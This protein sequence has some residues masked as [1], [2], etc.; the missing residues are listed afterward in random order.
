MRLEKLFSS[1]G[2][3]GA[4]VFVLSKGTA[5]M[6]A[7]VRGGTVALVSCLPPSHELFERA[8]TLGRVKHVFVLT[9]DQ[10]DH[11]SAWVKRF[12]A[13]L[14]SPCAYTGVDMLL[15]HDTLL[16]FPGKVFL[17]QSTLQVEVCL[18]VSQH[19]LVLCG[20]AVPVSFSD[21]QCERWIRSHCQSSC[22]LARDYELLLTTFRPDSFLSFSSQLPVARREVIRSIVE[23]NNRGLLLPVVPQSVSRLRILWFFLF[24]FNVFVFLV[25]VVSRGS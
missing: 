17:F 21:T 24:L 23:F 2:T 25:Y 20:S 7:V 3:N 10:S 18:F 5:R 6:H 16:P 12:G 4:D 22:N 11:A 8:E 9:S 1:G 15:A 13:L 14:W 19:R